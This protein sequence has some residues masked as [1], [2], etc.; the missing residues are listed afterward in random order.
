MMS[1]TLI[2]TKQNETE[3]TRTKGLA[4]PNTLRK[5]IFVQMV[6]ALEPAGVETACSLLMSIQV[7]CCTSLLEHNSAFPHGFPGHEGCV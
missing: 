2:A 7:H 4:Q 1:S 6:A 5:T 3:A